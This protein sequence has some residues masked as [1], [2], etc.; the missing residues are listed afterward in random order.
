M[1]VS[2][3]SGIT[4]ALIIAGVIA[5]VVIIIV[6]IAIVIIRN[7]IKVFF[8]SIN[9]SN[10]RI[11]Q[12]YEREKQIYFRHRNKEYTDFEISTI[13]P[14]CVETFFQYYFYIC[15]TEQPWLTLREKLKPGEKVNLI[16]ACFI[17]NVETPVKPKDHPFNDLT[18]E[19]LYCVLTNQ[20][21]VYFLEIDQTD[22]YNVKAYYYTE[23][24]MSSIKKIS[25]EISTETLVTAEHSIPV[26]AELEFNNGE[27]LRIPLISTVC[28]MLIEFINTGQYESEENQK[29]IRERQLKKVKALYERED[30]SDQIDEESFEKIKTL[31]IKT[32]PELLKEVE[33]SRIQYYENRHEEE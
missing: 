10:Q 1:D 17:L 32:M 14:I 23:F 20:N 16:T 6:I 5:V 18:Y 12:L 26:R 30:L 15:P 24:S 8:D 28:E 3:S 2:L 27:S 29:N 21:N 11:V 33:E 19:A 7:K 4:I 31:A 9:E 22:T 13:M 25:Y